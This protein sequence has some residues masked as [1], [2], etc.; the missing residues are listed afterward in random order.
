MSELC[1]GL[2]V[3]L[4]PWVRG[5]YG[6]SVLLVGVGVLSYAS[7]VLTG[8][9]C[10]ALVAASVGLVLGQ[11][12]ILR[13]VAGVST[14]EMLYQSETFLTGAATDPSFTGGIVGWGSHALRVVPASW[15][16]RL[17][18]EELS[19]ELVR[20]QWQL[21]NRLPGR[22]FLL[23]LVWSLTGGEGNAPL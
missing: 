22:A 16:V 17:P 20:R 1:P 6:Y 4:Q 15:L 2:A 18:Q 10:L 9:L 11:A 21:K 23:I 5:L 19:A 3:F 14:K 8:G 13:A 12:Q 7:F